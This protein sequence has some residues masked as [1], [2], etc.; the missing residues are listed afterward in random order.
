VV[1]CWLVTGLQDTRLCIF[2]R[3]LASNG[4]VSPLELVHHQSR[5]YL[6]CQLFFYCDRRRVSIHDVPKRS[7]SI[8]NRVAK[9]FSS[10][11]MKICPPSASSP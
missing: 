11:F 10:I 5:F 2:R 3:V 8:A 7:R 9:K 4:F 6:I 1:R